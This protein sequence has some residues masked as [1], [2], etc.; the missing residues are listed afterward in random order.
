MHLPLRPPQIQFPSS[1]MQT[2]YNNYLEFTDLMIREHDAMEAA[3]IMMAISLSIYK[4]SMNENDYY[5]IVD[6]IVASKDRIQT[7]DPPVIQ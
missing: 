7:F 4:T 3:G 6:S 5:R 1:K 2:L